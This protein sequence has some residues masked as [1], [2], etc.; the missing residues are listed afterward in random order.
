[1]RVDSRHAGTNLHGTKYLETFLAERAVGHAGRTAIGGM[2]GP[3]DKAR[4]PCKGATGNERPP[5]NERL[6]LWAPHPET[7]PSGLRQ[8]S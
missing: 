2:K 3:A 1:M 4:A 6:Y 7:W 8:Q 5:A